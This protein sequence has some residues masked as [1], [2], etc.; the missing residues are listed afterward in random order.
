MSDDKNVKYLW[1]NQIEEQKPERP[2]LRW[3]DY[4]EDSL[5]FMGVKR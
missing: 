4:A 5:K 3:L 1:E 2:I